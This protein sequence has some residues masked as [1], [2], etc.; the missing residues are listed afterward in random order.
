M[1]NL[2]EL[3]KVAQADKKT[4]SKDDQEEIIQRLF[5]MIINPIHPIPSIS[6]DAIHLN[7]LL[8]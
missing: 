5:R 4:L 8:V 6:F 1:A 7:L 2:D 3:L